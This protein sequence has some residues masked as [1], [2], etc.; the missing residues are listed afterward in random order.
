MRAPLSEAELH[1]LWAGQ[2]FPEAAL[3]TRQGAP[4]R[5]L[6]QGRRG[7]GPGPDFRG[8]L[9]AGP[10]GAAIRGDV[11][12]HLRASDFRAHGHHRDPAYDGVVLH[13]VFEDDTG[14][15]TPLASGRAAPVVALGPWVDRRAGEL[16]RWL[17]RPPL[18]REPCRDAVSPA[19]REGVL[20]RLDA[21]GQ[22]RFE[23]RAR[24]L[25]ARAAG[26]GLEEALY[27]ALLEALGYGG[28]RRAMGTLAERLPW[29]RL[30]GMLAAGA[31]PEELAQALLEALEPA[32]RLGAALRPLNRPERRL[33]GFALL[34]ARADGPAELLRA[35]ERAPATREII[36]AFTVA[37]PPDQPALIGRG[38]A[39][40]I[41]VNAVLPLAA[42]CGP[43]ELAA[44]AGA[45]YA[46][47][48]RPGRYG[49]L[50]FLEQALIP[51]GA[52]L[53]ARRQQGMLHLH[54]AWCQ[55]GRCA[56]CPLPGAAP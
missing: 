22:E 9:I 17:E 28:D 25:G 49:V 5:V 2:R 10:S 54:R 6:R 18:W 14:A 51:V 7:R 36:A 15:D 13:V 47:L 43:P 12:L 3:A 38:R 20:A 4:V 34:L 45:V 21:L 41:L 56:V 55:Q 27:R 24:E 46:A 31:P 40:E 44:R 33:R 19:V 30:S 23:G 11:E 52:R 32:A 1:D 39:I 26:I 29:R 35:L 50:V 8:A 42:A 48:P 53:T 37:G 16:R